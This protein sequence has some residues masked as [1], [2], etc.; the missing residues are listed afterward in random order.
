[1]KKIGIILVV[2]GV[3][4]I[5]ANGFLLNTLNNRLDGMSSKLDLLEVQLARVQSSANNQNLIQPKTEAKEKD[6]F[7][8][9]ELAEYLNIN[10]NQ[11]YD[12]IDAPGVGLPYVNIGGEYRF[13][14]EAIDEWLKG[15]KG[16]NTGN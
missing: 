3:I 6:V 16:E 12:M 13:G 4:L 8:P 14:K 15:N 9:T 5:A 7:T 1:M 11:V 2:L 10:I